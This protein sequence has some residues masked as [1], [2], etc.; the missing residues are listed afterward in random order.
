MA[1]TQTEAPPPELYE[2]VEPFVTDEG[3]A[4]VAYRKGEVVHPDDPYIKLM[5]ERFRAFVFPHPVRMTRAVTLTGPEVRA[6]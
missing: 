4:V 6:D 2:V 5:P 1:R 3:G